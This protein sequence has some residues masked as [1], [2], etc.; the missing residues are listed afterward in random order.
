[1]S[2]TI[3][4][5]IAHKKASFPKDPIYFPVEVGA[6]KH[7]EHFSPYQDNLGENISGKNETYCELT[8]I[9]WVYKNLD[10]DVVGLVHYRRYFLERKVF[11]KKKA[12]RHILSEK[13][14]ESILSTADFIVPKKRH[15][16][17][18][19]NYSHYLHVHRIEPLNELIKVLKADYPSYYESLNRYLKKKS[20]Y[21]FNM[22]VA[23]KE[24][25][26]KYLDWLFEVLRKVEPHVDVSTYTP[27]EKRAF[28]F[29]AELL[30]NAYIDANHL[31]ATEVPYVFTE[32]QHWVKKVLSFLRRKIIPNYGNQK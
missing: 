26:N 32:R 10:Y 2:K 1:M 12:F 13:T 29:L 21:Y 4:A 17:I 19:S 3:I 8:G 14:I 31:K 25:A 30:L 18:E 20:G 27:Y 22:F 7:T 28:G 24:V 5:V 15:Y 11:S 9:Y 6:E 16:F 23:S